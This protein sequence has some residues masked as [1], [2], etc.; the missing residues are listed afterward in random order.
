[1][2]VIDFSVLY[3]IFMEFGEKSVAKRS[4]VPVFNETNTV[5]FI[6]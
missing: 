1:M 6:I 2:L 4:A 5:L 3:K